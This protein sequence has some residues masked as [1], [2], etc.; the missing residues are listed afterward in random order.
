LNCQEAQVLIHGYADGELDLM[1]SLEIEQHLQ[2]CPACERAHA[3]LRAVRAAIQDSSL[4]YQ[5]PPG[6]AQRVQSS[7]R[8]ASHADRTP[9]VLPPRLLAVAA[10]LAL[11][12]AAG[13]GLARALSARSDDESLTQEL[14]AGHV[15][16]QMLP[17]H[18]FD[19]ASSD[20]HTVKPWFEGKLDFAPPVK[21]LAGQGFP[22]VGGRLDYL[23]N[24]PVAALVY[25]RRKHSINLFIWPSAPGSETTSRMATRQGYHL[26]QWTQSGMTFWTVSDLNERELQDFVNLI[27][28]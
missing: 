20:P 19:V 24:R 12:V 21:D 17:S 2:E 7:V 27:K 18:R 26:F 22:L 23:H 11:I 1:E 14:V 15:R 13:W 3:S 10:S 9:R 25:Q 16:S 5:A 28:S 4:Y 8:G 6:L